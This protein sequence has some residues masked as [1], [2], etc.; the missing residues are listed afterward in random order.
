MHKEQ[1]R[2]LFQIGLFIATFVTT[3]LAGAEWTYGKSVF[4]PGYSWLDFTSGLSFSIP[5]LLILTVHEFG[6]YFVAVYHKVRTSL[7]YYIPF[8]PIPFIP[9]YLGTMGAIIRLRSKPESNVQNFDI[10]VAGPVAGFVVAILILFY[11]FATLPPAD[12]IYQFHP[13]YK[14][15]GPAYA[16]VVYSPEYLKER[17]SI[18]DV[19]IGT[20]LIFWIFE[21]TVADP[22]RVPNAHEIMH[23]PI[24]LACYWA[25]FITCLNLLPIGQLD[26]GHIVYG[27]FG[28]KAHRIIA[29]VSFLLLIF[30][31]GLGLEYINPALPKNSLLIGIAGYL[32][33]LFLAFRGLKLP[34]KDTLMYVIV[35][36]GVQFSITAFMPGVEGYGGWLLFAFIVGRFIG[37]D[38]PPSELERPLDPGRVTI[39]WIAL[40]IF[41]LC[42]SPAPL[43]AVMGG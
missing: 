27:L 35:M 12:Y 39:G 22:S 19:T 38:H 20:N 33:F 29:L 14:Q 28:F 34:L 24:L 11:G 23:Y 32:L 36:F 25:L 4:A 37:I 31:A 6:H 16:E 42:F 15:F 10:G 26:G 41:I 21:N 13:E 3:T 5:L 8:P 43:N 1:K 2:I 30:Y 18:I 9:F 17:P 7:P 40:I